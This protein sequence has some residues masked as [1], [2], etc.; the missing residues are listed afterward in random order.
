MK[1]VCNLRGTRGSLTCALGIRTG[2]IPSVRLAPGC[3]WATAPLF[4]PCDPAEALPAGGAPDR[5]GS[6]HRC[7]ASAGQNHPPRARWAWGTRGQAARRS[8]RSRVF[9][10]TARPQRWLRLRPALPPKARPT[11]TRRWASRRVRRAQG[12]D[13]RQPFGED[14]TA[15]GTIAAEPLADAELEAHA[16]RCPRQIGQGPCVTTVDTPRGE[17]TQRT[18]H[19]GL[20]RMHQERDLRR[21]GGDVTGGKA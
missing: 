17:R 3:A 11:A 13:R 9:R 19:V 20:R 1:A 16:V 10:L 6:C 21:R 7:A 12:C 5:R 15:A 8:R 18:G 2:P 4:R 14:A